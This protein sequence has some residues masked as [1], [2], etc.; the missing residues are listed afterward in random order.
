MW[1]SNQALLT[2][3]KTQPLLVFLGHVSVTI[4]AASVTQQLCLRF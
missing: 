3:F 2:R 1:E 4:S